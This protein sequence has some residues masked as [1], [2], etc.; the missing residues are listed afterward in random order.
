MTMNIVA[1]ASPQELL[2][3]DA[4]LPE[5]KIAEH[6]I[7]RDVFAG[8]LPK[9]RLKRLILTL[10]PA[11]SGPGRYAFAAKVSQVSVDDGKRLFEDIYSALKK[12]E[13]NADRGWRAVAKAVGCTDAEIDAELRNPSA[14][15]A[16][17]LHVIREH[18]LRSTAV[19]ASLI[20]WAVERHL[21]VIWGRLA[22][23]LAAHYQVD[24]S[25]LEF[26]RHEAARADATADWIEH[27]VRTYVYPADPYKVFEARRAAREAVWAWT[28]ITEAN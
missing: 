6:P 3:S 9:P 18:S 4:A 23:A 14:E 26:L 25:A 5:M 28:V 13:A 17:Y 24:E 1:S 11:V 8:K 20:A 7:W 10:L 27:L 12:P 15:A 2:A 19:E 21:P 16:D 22:D